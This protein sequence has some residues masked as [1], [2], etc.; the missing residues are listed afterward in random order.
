[1]FIVQKSVYSY[2]GKKNRFEAFCGN[3]LDFYF[4]DGRVTFRAVAARGNG[5]V[6]AVLGRRTYR[7]TFIIIISSPKSFKQFLVCRDQP[8]QSCILDGECD[9]GPP[10]Y[11]PGLKTTLDPLTLVPLR[12]QTPTRQQTP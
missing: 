1:M 5:R 3:V 9:F 8:A 2:E 11:S 4:V 6:V 7:Y 12:L 10:D